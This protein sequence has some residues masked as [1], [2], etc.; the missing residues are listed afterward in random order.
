MAWPGLK[1]GPSEKTSQAFR[2]NYDFYWEFFKD[3]KTQQ[4]KSIYITYHLLVSPL[5]HS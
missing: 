2:N 4:K 5:F 1:A 3:Q